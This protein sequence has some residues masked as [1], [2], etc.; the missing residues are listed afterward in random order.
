M[1][2]NLVFYLFYFVLCIDLGVGGYNGEEDRIIV[3]RVYVV[4]M[5]RKINKKL[6][7]ED[8]FRYC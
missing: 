7:K 1:E 8:N 3:F 5:G 4:V 2:Y 6:N